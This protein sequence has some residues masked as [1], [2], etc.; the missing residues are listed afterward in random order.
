MFSRRN[1]LINTPLAAAGML[2]A[3]RDSSSAQSVV[4][5]GA[6]APQGPPPAAPRPLLAD[7][8]ADATTLEWIPKHTDLVYTFGGA[9]PRQRIKPKTRIVTFGIR[10]AHPGTGFG[11][12]ERGEALSD[13]VF[14]IRRFCEKP[15]FD[16]AQTYV[17][18]GRYDWNAGIFL[19]SPQV[20][21]QEL[22][23]HAPEVLAHTREAF[24][25]ARRDGV[26]ISLDEQAFA[27]VPS[28]SVD[29]AV[30]EKTQASA[31][32]PCDIGW[33]DVGGF[34]E[35]WRLGEKDGAANHVKGDAILIEAQNC[36][37][38]N[39]GPVVAVIGLSD[40]MVISTPAGVLVAPIE[41][42]QDV[43]KAAEAARARLESRA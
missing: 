20:M 14:G 1:F 12:I 42:A 4:Q 29:Y 9:A 31:V 33:A 10:A 26:V 7:L 28:I 38:H 19:F 39:S 3:C 15:D 30:M 34:A 16:T 23:R 21:L 8:P 25:R 43:K 5:A 41:R 35:L 13:G 37:V 18:S 40:I 36:L 17:A 11:Y 27:R 24:D 2:A 22:Q 6:A 32:A